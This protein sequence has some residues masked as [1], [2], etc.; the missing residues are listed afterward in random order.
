VCIEYSNA[1]GQWMGGSY[2]TC[3]T[4]TFDWTRIGGDTPPVPEGAGSGTVVLYLRKHNTGT[5]WFDDV[6]VKAIR[7]PAMQVR[8]LR[9]TYRATVTTPTGGKSIQALVRL[10]RREY[11]LPKTV[12]V[13]GDVRDASGKPLA[14][15]AF[16]PLS[17]DA[18]TFSWPLPTL[19]MGRHTLT[20]R[21]NGGGDDDSSSS[22][23]L[24]V[25]EPVERRVRL[26]EQG[27][28]IAEG[29]PFFPLGLYLGPTED[30][31]LE[32]IAKGGFNTIL[33]YGYGQAREPR[34]YLDRA[35]KHGLRVIY[36]IKDLYKGSKYYRGVKGLSD[37]EAMRKYITD[38]RDHPALLAWYTNDELAPKWLPRLM[39]AY[40]L[41]CE[42]D[43]HHPAFQVLCRPTEFDRYYDVLDVF[44]CD[45]Y[46]VPRKPVTLVGDW[47]ETSHEA[48]SRVKPV[49]CVPQIFAWNNYTSAEKD[50]EPTFAEKR[51]MI[52]LALIHGARGLVCYSYYDLFK[53]ASK[54]T[55]AAPEVFERRWREVSA[56]AGHVRKII[57]DLLE[58]ERSE[59]E[60]TQSV[61][62]LKLVHGARTV[63]IAVN[64][65]AEAPAPFVPPGNALRR[66]DGPNV[67]QL[68]PLEGAIYVSE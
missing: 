33:C 25:A 39:A 58:A 46:P 45:P 10:N 21:L 52:Y 56:I 20:V 11:S 1:K 48:V 26:D 19:P 65:N 13:R 15:L 68:G 44:G 34:A 32:R 59:A 22:V 4:G 28:L 42:L 17:G 31:H 43:P 16:R 38:F 7:G 30:E 23:P 55:K 5:A 60:L 40:D 54:G 24:R 29:K 62:W 53:G 8:L 12:R 14:D 9:P 27:R 49:W 6:V 57:P 2:P 41:V 67:G 18:E 66:L 64:T 36:S 51:A 3:R 35:Q 61:R 63:V 50:R 47:M 37:I